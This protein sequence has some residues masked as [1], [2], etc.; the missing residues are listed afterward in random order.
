MKKFRFEPVRWLTGTALVLGAALEVDRQYQILP[1]GWGHYVAAGAAF[2]ALLVVGAK[3]RSA[4]TPLAAPKLDED[5][6]LV[7]LRRNTGV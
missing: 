6:P 3:A 7:P 2:V 4:A 5:T 1:A